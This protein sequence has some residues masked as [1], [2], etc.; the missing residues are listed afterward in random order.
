MIP[1]LCTTLASITFILVVYLFTKTLVE[2][3]QREFLLARAHLAMVAKENHE[4]F[5]RMMESLH[6]N[7]RRVTEYTPDSNVTPKGT[8][9]ITDTF[10]PAMEA[11]ASEEE[12]ANIVSKRNRTVVSFGEDVSE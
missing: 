12:I 10:R 1:I 2:N 4:Q 11:G 5:L 9:A 8:P 7:S 6:D 3:I